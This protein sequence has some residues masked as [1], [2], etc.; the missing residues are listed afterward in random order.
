MIPYKMIKHILKTSNRKFIAL[1]IGLLIVHFIYLSLFSPLS[2]NGKWK[3][4]KIP[5]GSTYTQGINILKS[6]GIINNG[7][8]FFVLGAVTDIDKQLRAGYYNLNTSMSHWNVFDNLRRGMI[9]QYTVTLPEGDNLDIIKTKLKNTGIIDDESWQIVHDRDFLDSLKIDAPSLEGYIYPDTY[10]FAKGMD[11]KDVF[12]MM[13]QRLRENLDQ[14]LMDRA[15]ELE[16]SERDVLTLASIIEKEALV[17]RE[18]PLI[19]AVY[20]NRLKKHMKLQAD[21]TVNYGVKKKRNKISRRD[22]NRVTPYNTYVIEGLPPG[23]IASPGIRSIKA[24]LYPADV[25]YIYFVSKNN[26]T[27]HFSRTG[28]EHLE[29]VDLYQRKKTTKTAQKNE[30]EKTD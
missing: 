22:L 12:R 27:H 20:H 3:E 17:N 25:D 23:P 5:K 1:S 18:R 21:P 14:V 29:A 24:A 15:E 4:V 30:E 28:E 9:L 10:S 8:I 7:F 19:S 26:G 6:E 11:H 13:V 16:M 2:F